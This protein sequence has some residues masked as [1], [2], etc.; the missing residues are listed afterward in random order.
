MNKHLLCAAALALVALASIAI[1]RKNDNDNIK[2]LTD[3]QIDAVIDSCMKHDLPQTADP[4]FDEAKRRTRLA[5]DNRRMLQ[6]IDAQLSLNANRIETS[7][8]MMA[9]I[10]KEIATAP[11]PLAEMLM[12]RKA[13]VA[14]YEYN[15]FARDIYARRDTLRKISAYTMVDSAEI[16]VPMS[17]YDYLMLAKYQLYGRDLNDN[18]D[19]W[20][21]WRDNGTA[22]ST[23]LFEMLNLA[24]TYYGDEAAVRAALARINAAICSPETEALAHFAI[25]KYYYNEATENATPDISDAYADTATIHLKLAQKIV[26]HDAV[27]NYLKNIDA[28]GLRATILDSYLPNN[29][30]PIC[31]ETKNLQSVGVDI[32]KIDN[33]NKKFTP[34]GAKPIATYNFSIPKAKGRICLQN[35][36][37]ELNALNFGI[38][39]VVVH[40]DTLLVHRAIKITDINAVKLNSNKDL[41]MALCS[42]TTGSPLTA[43]TI[44][45]KKVD[46]LGMAELTRSRKYRSHTIRNGSDYIVVESYDA[47]VSQP[48]SYVSKRIAS[49]TDRKIYRPGQDVELKVWLYHADYEK[50]WAEKENAKIQVRL[51]SHNGNKIADT[52][53]VANGFGTASCTLHLPTDIDLGYA[54]LWFNSNGYSTGTNYIDIE[55]YKRSGNRI[56]FDPTTAAIAP[57]DSVKVSGTALSADD[58]PIQNARIEMSCNRNRDTTLVTNMLGAYS[59]YIH[60]D[61]TLRDASYYI[62]SKLTD[63]S[64]ETTEA[65]TNVRVNE[66][67]STLN[68]N[69]LT[70]WLERGDSLSFVINS[71]NYN[72]RPYKN[73]VAYTLLKLKPEHEYMPRLRRGIS[74]GVDEIIGTPTYDLGSG[75]DYVVADT[76][77]K[78][79]VVVDGQKRISIATNGLST[80]VYRI[81]ATATS[82][83]GKTQICEATTDIRL[84]EGK[85][86]LSKDVYLFADRDVFS[87]DTD[88]RFSVGTRLPKAQML[89]VVEYA[90]KVVSRQYVALSGEIKRLSVHVPTSK[91]NYQNMNIVA[92]IV[93]DGTTYSEQLTVRKAEDVSDIEMKLSTWRD[94]SIPGATET[95]TLTLSSKRGTPDAEI[96]ASMYD[97]RLDRI[98]SNAWNTYFYR[99]SLTSHLYTPTINAKYEVPVWDKNAPQRQ[100]G[101]TSVRNTS[102]GVLVDAIEVYANSHNPMYH[103]T[104]NVRKSRNMAG[105]RSF[106]YELANEEMAETDAMFMVGSASRSMVANKKMAM[107]DSADEVSEEEMLADEEADEGDDGQQLETELDTAQIRSDFRETVFFY[108]HLRTDSIGNA[109][110]TFTLPDNLTTYCFRAIAHDKQMNKGYITKNMIVSKPLTI[111]A[112]LPRVL[113]E[114]DTITISMTAQ[115]EEEVSNVSAELNVNGNVQRQR[116]DGA[117]KQHQFSFSL[118][119][120]D[121]SVDSLH[122]TLSATNGH[123]TDGERH[124]LPVMPRYREIS[125]SQPFMLQTEGVHNLTNPFA[126]NDKNLF[127]SLSYTCNTWTEVLRALPHLYNCTYPSSDTYLGHIESAA[128]AMQLKQ[129]ADVQE[130]AENLRNGNGNLADHSVEKT[131]PWARFNNFQTSHDEQVLR[132]L[133]GSNAQRTYATALRNLRKMQLADGSFPWFKGMDGS[134]GITR[135]ILETLGMLARYGIVSSADVSDMCTKGRAYIERQIEKEVAEWDRNKIKKPEAS[136]LTLHRLYTLSC[137]GKVN[138]NNTAVQRAINSIPVASKM[139]ETNKKLMAALVLVR[140]GQTKQAQLLMRS[141]CENL[142]R[143][144]DYS[145]HV[146]LRG[147]LWYSN[148]TFVHAM[149]I[150][151]INEVGVGVADQPRVINW[152]LKEK[153]STHW[154][155]VQATSRAVLALLTQRTDNRH[156]DVVAYA[157]KSIEVS[158]Q[159]TI[160]PSPATT[161]ITHTSQMASWGSWQRTALLATDQMAASNN[162]DISISRTISGAERVGDKATITLTVTTSVDMDFVR[163]TDYRPAAFEPTDQKSQYRGWWRFAGGPVTPHYF[164]PHDEAVDFFVERLPRGTHTFSYQCYITNAGQMNAGY[165]EAI[166]M[167]TDGLEAHTEGAKMRVE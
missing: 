87:P 154:H 39:E 103:R 100:A 98:V 31:L 59:Y 60:T 19:I 120:P 160:T 90:G 5:N 139:Q 167:Y 76:I 81:E 36:Y 63:L 79:I 134:E 109:S 155:D 23:M 61:S 140:I 93:K 83:T 163:I 114:G 115:C 110:F 96:V 147:R 24:D 51:N 102:Y 4:Y 105:F 89:V 113:T 118:V 111:K 126:D 137:I 88:F 142:V 66:Y 37:V 129:R 10:D 153:R 33:I 166:C 106:N 74:N 15:N 22:V 152:L 44:D 65:S 27:D 71:E 108:P 18:T 38:Y 121:G 151:A 48:K 143:P 50:K 26:R 30:I 9:T 32:Y 3:R 52:T 57:G 145:A 161:T 70:N 2:T 53:I 43:A 92:H 107:F 69:N 72:G 11:T 25:G 41:L 16:V 135:H 35:T 131:S 1:G 130:W 34:M 95:A 7:R 136:Y 144:D 29:K 42:A 150:L 28:K 101:T 119:A 141:V 12:L 49:V 73:T 146:S 133:S 122:I 54:T 6:L 104:Y 164:S 116:S 149:L 82:Y 94:H 91:L 99:N 117:S 138:T 123:F 78:N 85:C 47:E 8:N 97:N 125:E 84:S 13:T 132:M 75:A 77:M 45:G 55:E 17:L 112:W 162:A 67:G 156:V 56:V 20:H 165:A 158:G 64:G 86:E 46:E 128:I 148:T 68:I 14:H 58:K 127:S 159:T 21:D 124:T 157:D 80:G 62:T 40:A